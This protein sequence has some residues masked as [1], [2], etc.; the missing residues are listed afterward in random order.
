M[1]KKQLDM[2]LAWKEAVR[3]FSGNL[4]LSLAIAG[5]F[6]LIPALLLNW[7]GT[8]LKVDG[9]KSFE[10]FRELFN[11]FVMQNWYLLLIDVLLAS[12]GTI[13]LYMLVLNARRPTVGEALAAASVL[14]PAYFAAQILSGLLTFFGIMLLIVPGVYL[15]IKF[16]LVAPVLAAEDIRSPV[17]AMRRSWALTKNNSV[18][19]FMFVLMV[20]LVGILVTAGIG[21][22]INVPIALLLSPETA[23]PVTLLVSTIL[24]TALSLFLLYIMMAIYVQ[25]AAQKG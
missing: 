4:D 22:A 19:I 21:L 2:G 16:A 7:F 20:A 6:M 1:E 13:A 5:V 15:A 17:A 10:A 8:P 12:I 14:F 24:N 3:L 23:E 9:V 25:M 11:A 18:L